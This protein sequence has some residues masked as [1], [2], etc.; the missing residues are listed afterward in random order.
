MK[1]P[2]YYQREA[3]DALLF[4]LNEYRSALMVGG[5]GCG[6]TVIA[7]MLVAELLPAVCLY[8]ADQNELCDQ[9]IAMFNSE[10]NITPAVD[11]ARQ[12]ASLQSKLIVASAQTL[13]NPKRLE[14]FPPGLV[15]YAIVDEA[16]RGADRDQKIIQHLGCKV[17]GMT[18][19]PFKAK[20]RDLTQYYEHTAYK[21]GIVDLIGEGFAPPWDVD[22]VPVE[23]DLDKVRMKRGFDGKDFDA[24]SLDTTI[25]PYFEKI[26]DILLQKG[27]GNKSVMIRL[28]LIKSSIAFTQLC[29]QAGIKAAHVDGQSEDRRHLIRAFAAGDIQWIC[30]ANLL[31]TGVD[32]PRA[33]VAVN[34][35]PTWSAVK[36]WQF[37]GRIMRV[38][39]GVIDD[40]P[41]KDQAEERKARI[42]ASAKPRVLIMDFLW[43]HEKMARIQNAAGLIAQNE[44]ELA[45][46]TAAIRKNH[47]PEDLLKIQ[48]AVQAE[49]E[50]NL[51]KQLERVA[52]EKVDGAIDPFAFGMLLQSKELM[53][54]EPETANEALPASEAQLSKLAQWKIDTSKV[55]CRGHANKLMSNMIFRF[56]FKLATANQLRRLKKMGIPYDP[57]KL[58]IGEASRLIST[59]SLGRL[60]VK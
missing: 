58:T 30:S 37:I 40:L 56:K 16:H 41:E 46:I 21:M 57:W 44:D 52:T 36:Y 10:L 48:A 34:L 15:K 18:A 14:R 17:I 28:P 47:S 3:R 49:R 5:T 60:R 7:A 53:D 26:I 25:A 23:I 6:K 20:V 4:A 45:A 22:V 35:A 54:Y 24:E 43:Q 31:E 13:S 2:R 11:K 9:P 1:I 50:A 29:L 32:I 8:L 51:V 12:F 55:T 39:G 59:W 42:A 19:T 33:E 38:L 27:L